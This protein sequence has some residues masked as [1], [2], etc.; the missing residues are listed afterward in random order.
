MHARILLALALAVGLVGC[1]R[2]P[3]TYPVQGKID[4]VGGDVSVLAGSTIEAAQKKDPLVRAAGAIQPDGTFRLETLHAGV[5]Y[6]GALEGDYQ[7]RVILGDDDAATRRRAAKAVP[8]RYYE[9][10]T[11]GLSLSVPA[12]GTVAL[13]LE[14]R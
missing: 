2:G 5:I 7:V 9:F 8:R 4:L 1:G 13:R 3:T 6:S 14:P 10:D 11:A 12:S